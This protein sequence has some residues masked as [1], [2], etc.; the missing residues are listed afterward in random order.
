LIKLAFG[1]G[2]QAALKIANVGGTL[3]DITAYTTSVNLTT[4]RDEI[5]V[6]TMG[7][8]YKNWLAGLQDASL[9]TEGIHDPAVAA[10]LFPLGTAASTN[11]EYG[12]QGTASGAEKYSGTCVRG[13]YNIPAGIEDAVTYVCAFHIKGTVT[14]GTF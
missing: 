8:T 1:P 2:Y 7:A 12:P 14:R 5:D 13:D 9:E 4:S 11:F 6:T 10:I 3:Q